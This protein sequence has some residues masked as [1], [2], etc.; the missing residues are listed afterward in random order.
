MSP[1]GANVLATIRDPQQGTSDV[2]SVDVARGTRTRL[3]FD[4]RDD[5]GARWSPD[6]E[7]I[8][9]T[10][11]REGFYNLYSVAGGGGGTTETVLKS[12]WTMVGG[13]FVRGKYSDAVSS[14]D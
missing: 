4:P 7:R 13:L 12:D 2:W 10:S 3:T 11:D 14:Q 6:G 5:F 9:F 1:D 8:V